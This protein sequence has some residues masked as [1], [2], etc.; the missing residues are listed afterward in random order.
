MDQQY[1]SLNESSFL[2]KEL[3]RTGYSVDQL[4]QISDKVTRGEVGEFLISEGRSLTFGILHAIYQDTLELHR[5]Y[6]FKRGSVKALVRMIPMAFS[7]ISM[8]A[9]Y[10]GMA[11]GSTR[12]VNKI[13]KPILEDP[14][15]TY[16]DFLKKIISKSMDVFEGEISGDD[17]IK[18][19][20]VVCD[21]LVDMLS[22]KVI[23]EFV[24]HQSEE[25]AKESPDDVVPDFYIENELRSYLNDK[26]KLN[27]P[28]GQR[29]L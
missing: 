11:L 20:F 25:M 16:P 22:E 8:L 12:A 6:E 15:K 29:L 1:Y 27:P 5:N 24:V 9:S 23:M 3:M 7:P 28:L 2:K 26:F 17:P 21:G 13:I 4:S 18:M 10:I 14:G 19:A